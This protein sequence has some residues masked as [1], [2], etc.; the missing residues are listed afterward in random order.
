MK[1]PGL[2]SVKSR[3]FM[4]RA[5]QKWFKG[6][7]FAFGWQLLRVLL[8]DDHVLDWNVLLQSYMYV[9]SA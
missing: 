7:S 2:A 1:C 3:G 6:M 8:L 4:V 9:G 5:L